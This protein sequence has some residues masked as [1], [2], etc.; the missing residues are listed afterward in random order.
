VSQ[1]AGSGPKT[2]TNGSTTTTLAPDPGHTTGV[3]VPATEK[4]QPLVGCG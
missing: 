1:P 3:T 2:T 4:G